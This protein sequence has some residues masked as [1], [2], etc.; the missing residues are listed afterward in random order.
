MR[1][2]FSDLN[3][4]F[5][6]LNH[7]TIY[8]VIEIQFCDC[9]QFCK[10]ATR[11]PKKFFYICGELTIKKEQRNITDF[12]KKLYFDYFGVKLGDQDKSCF[13]HIICCICLEE[14]KQWLSEK[15]KSLRFGIPMIW[16]ETSNQS[17]EFYF[18]SLNVHVFNAKNR[19]GI[20][21][22]NIPSAMRPVPHGPGIPI[23]KP[24]E[25]LKG[26]SSD[27]EEED[28]GSVDD[29]N[30]AGS[31]DPQLFSQSELNDLVSDLRLPKY[32]AELLGSR[33]NEKKNIGTWCL[34]FM[35]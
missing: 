17:D 24:P 35:V 9:G 11:G 31:N 14:L 16:R 27:S 30:A 28:D 6:Q 2:F 23:P 8:L 32:F 10:V 12:V 1:I 33:L 3:F 22:P 29:S 34:F 21:Y 18:C 7:H 26:I 25:K 15:Q 20:I 13:P 5:F 4:R 19:K